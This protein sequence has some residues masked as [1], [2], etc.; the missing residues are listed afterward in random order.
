MLVFHKIHD[1]KL[2]QELIR[3]IRK[4]VRRWCNYAC[5]TWEDHKNSDIG[6]DDDDDN[7]SD[8]DDG[9]GIAGQPKAVTVIP[10]PCLAPTFSY[11]G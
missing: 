8:D 11:L 5:N 1:W 2:L 4:L 3:V 6:H 10:L 7:D 9:D